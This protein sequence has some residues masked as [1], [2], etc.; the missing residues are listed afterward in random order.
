MLSKILSRPARLI[1]RAALFT[2]DATTAAAPSTGVVA[3]H[4]ISQMNKDTDIN[5][6]FELTEAQIKKNFP[7]GL[8]KRINELFELVDPHKHF[9][10][11]KPVAEIL[12]SMSNFPENWPKQWP[13]RAF[14]LDGDRGTG[15]TVSLIQI[16]NYARESGWIVL[17]VPHARTW[18][19]D[20]P[21]VT[22]SAFVEG[23]FDIDV[24]G[25][26][27]LKQFIQCHKDQLAQLPLR[28]DYGDRYYPH[29]LPKKPKSESEYNKSDL[30]LLDICENGLKDDLLSCQAVID[31]KNELAQVT[32]VPVLVAVDEYN[33]WFEK[34]V[35]GYEGVEVKPED[36]TIVDAF[37]D[38]DA[39]GFRQDRQLKNGLFIA[40]TT[41]NYP[42][43]FDFSKQATYKR[44][45]K[46]LHPYSNEEL[47]SVVD[48]LHHINF[49]Q[50]KY[51]EQDVIYLRLMTK[52]V[53]LQVFKQA[54]IL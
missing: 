36:I 9:M 4:C 31:L 43:R 26:D 39:T 29:T 41:K 52:N 6:F 22:K 45:R 47:T 23:K 48:Y 53:P 2:T 30:T 18:V 32:E 17:H 40:A 5:K 24:I 21:Y 16:V 15:K 50:A 38:V 11:R 42:S 49:R 46:L 14:V 10:L 1:S 7:N 12:S 34:T 13:E 20:A 28:G 44:V 27:I 51:S 54:C 25:M 8:P 19:Q 3:D 35:F 33:A 37:R